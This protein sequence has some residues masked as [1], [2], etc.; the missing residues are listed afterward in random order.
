MRKVSLVAVAASAALALSAAAFGSSA[1]A[2][3]SNPSPSPTSSPS[4][5]S[6][7]GGVFGSGC[8]SVTAS[9]GSLEA[10]AKVPVGTA[11]ASIPELSTVVAA[12]QKA[13]MVDTLNTA[14]DITVFAPVNSAFAKIPPDQLNAVL[15]NPTQL[16]SVLSYHVVPQRLSPSQL[17]GTHKTLQ[18]SNLTVTGS[19]QN[20]TVNGMAQIVCG[21]IQTA[22]AT[23]YLINTVLIPQ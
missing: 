23:V 4:T 14:K 18:G 15:S 1:T 10:L 16:K 17:A 19:G 20:F 7:S 3:P 5:T 9:P 22:N 12:V 2:A 8:S 13:G 11:A 21:N 6:S